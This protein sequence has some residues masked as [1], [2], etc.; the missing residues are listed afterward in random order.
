MT[1]KPKKKTTAKPISTK[2]RNNRTKRK[3]ETLLIQGFQ[4]NIIKKVRSKY[5]KSYE[6]TRCK[7]LG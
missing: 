4:G 7:Y 5:L 3:A 2:K 1:P 6:N